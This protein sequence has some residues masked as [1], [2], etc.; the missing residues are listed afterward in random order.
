MFVCEKCKKQTEH[1]EKQFK[2][3]VQIRQVVYPDCGTAG[4]EIVKELKVCKECADAVH[5]T[6]K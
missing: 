1:K 2:I 5:K 4:W 6:N 3:V